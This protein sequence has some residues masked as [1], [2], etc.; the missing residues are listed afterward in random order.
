MI[1]AKRGMAY[2]A[3]FSLGAFAVLYHY[4]R[5]QIDGYL[6]TSH[7]QPQDWFFW[8]FGLACVGGAVYSYVKRSGGFDW[9]WGLWLAIGGVILY[10]ELADVIWLKEATCRILAGRHHAAWTGSCYQPN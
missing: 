4:D 3:A 7:L 1:D 10:A 5:P 6:H 2:A 9:R 8:M